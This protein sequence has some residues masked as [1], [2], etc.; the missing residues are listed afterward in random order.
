M[1]LRAWV[2]E[3]IEPSLLMSFLGTAVAAYEGHFNLP[4]YLLAVLGVTLALL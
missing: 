4:Y 3:A 1:S 2:G